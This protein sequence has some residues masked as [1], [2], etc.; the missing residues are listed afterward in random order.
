MIGQTLKP[1]YFRPSANVHGDDTEGTTTTLPD[2]SA[3]GEEEWILIDGTPASCVQIG[4]NHFFQDKPPVDLVLSGPNFGRNTTAIFALSSGTLG[5]ALEAASCKVK[6]IAVSFA[7]FTRNHD[8]VIIDAACRQSIKVIEGLYGQWPTDGSVD[9]YSVNV[10]LVEGV[11]T[12]KTYLTKILQ[13]YWQGGGCFV[14][15]ED[16]S[17]INPS[18]DEAKIREGEGAA[19]TSTTNNSG[20]AGHKHKHFKWSP[21]FTDVFS[22]VEEAGPGSD[23]WVVK[24]GHTRYASMF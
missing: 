4:L 12:H 23:G 14:E 17:A 18:L 2:P 11:D 15:I 16:P 6:S 22:S 20:C 13:N 19:A 9:L 8:P 10:P 1:S 5:G 21:N 3:T 24:E 7:F